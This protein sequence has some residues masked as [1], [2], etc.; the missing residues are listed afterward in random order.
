MQ[1]CRSLCPG[2]APA[3]ASWMKKSR[4]K[5]R[6]HATGLALN[7]IAGYLSVIP[8]QVFL[9]WLPNVPIQD[10]HSWVN[11]AATSAYQLKHIFFMLNQCSP[12]HASK[13]NIMHAEWQTI[14]TPNL[15]SRR[16]VVIIILLLRVVSTLVTCLRVYTTKEHVV[17]LLIIVWRDFSHKPSNNWLKWA[18]TG[19]YI[20]FIG[21]DWIHE[22]HPVHFLHLTFYLGWKLDVKKM[23]S[24]KSGCGKNWP[25]KFC[26][27]NILPSFMF[28]WTRLPSL[29]KILNLSLAGVEFGSNTPHCLGVEDLQPLKPPMAS[30]TL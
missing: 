23:S 1:E 21:L 9:I 3:S 25:I 6:C 22:V 2:P 16:L 27:N 17:E 4:C 5:C 18:P 13:L 29:T 8:L 24:K 14:L 30:I 11:C 28:F 15:Y 10:T 7:N 12:T 19:Y 26:L 20:S